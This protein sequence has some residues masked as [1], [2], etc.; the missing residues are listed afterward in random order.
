MLTGRLLARMVK[1][2]THRMTSR[3]KLLYTH[4]SVADDWRTNGAILIV[5]LC[6][7]LVEVVCKATIF[8]MLCVSVVKRKA[9]AVFQYTSK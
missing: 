3:M 2:N 7:Q 4:A 1:L 9:S 5:H 6:L 8:P